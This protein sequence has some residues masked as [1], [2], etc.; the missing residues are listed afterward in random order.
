MAAGNA[1]EPQ[2]N[3]LESLKLLSLCALYILISASLINGNKYLMN[4]ER[5]P[6]S[7]AL[8]L[9]HVT[10]TFSCCALLYVVAPGL[11]PTMQTALTQ[12]TQIAK[13]FP[14]ISVLFIIGVVASNEA[15]LYCNV[16]F[17]QFMKEWNVALVFMFSCISGSQVCDR[18]KFVV[19]MWIVA[20][21][22]TAVTGDMKF[23]RWGFMIQCCSQLGETTKA[24]LQEYLLGGSGLKLD[25]LTYL[26]FISPIMIIALGC[27]DAALF[28]T[29]MMTAALNSWR[30]ILASSLCA[31]CLNLI[32]AV[33]IKQ[34]GAMAF[35]MSGLVKD[36]VIV[37]SS[38]FI[39]NVPLKNQEI[40]GF[41]LSLLGM[42][43]W[44]FMKAV[45]NHPLIRWLPSLLH[46]CEDNQANE[47]MPLM[48]PPPGKA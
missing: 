37:V 45:P 34:G 44:G 24:V 5:F 22:C 39:Y 7:A 43:Y 12:K 9:S 47:K 41:T 23:S 30:L 16:A 27:I 17:L 11:F 14:L 1:A 28:T 32:I 4:P 36:I 3:P 29:E 26:M 46:G 21:S 40:F 25:P 42:G 31:F 48:S 33:I 15:Y 38:S 8:T 35:I 2:F 10:T 18:T 6:Y 13:F 20:F 19:L